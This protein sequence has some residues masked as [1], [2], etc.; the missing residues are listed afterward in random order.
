MSAAHAGA[1]RVSLP[2]CRRRL[3]RWRAGSSRRRLPRSLGSV[4][5]AGVA[6]V[7]ITFASICGTPTHT[8][9][10]GTFQALVAAPDVPEVAAGGMKYSRIT[11]MRPSRISATPAT[12]ADIS[13]SPAA[14]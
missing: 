3:R 2:A 6:P 5:L 11:M 7:T 14:L 10:F 12:R 4:I 9:I 8:F 1:A 13:N